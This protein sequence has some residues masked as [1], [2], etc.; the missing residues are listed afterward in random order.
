MHRPRIS[1]GSWAFSFGPFAG[2]PWPFDRLCR[3]A[4]EAGYEG[5]E[6]NGFRPHPHPDDF[7]TAQKCLELRRSI[8]DLGLGVSGYA[9][10]FRAAP[11]ALARATEYFRVLDRCLAFCN[12]MGTGILRVD[13]VSPPVALAAHEYEARFARLSDTWRAA[14]ERCGRA[15]VTMVWEFEPGFWLN[16]P[17]EVK[18]LVETVAH[19]AFRVLFDASHAHMGAVVGARQ[20][21][22]TETLRGGV[23]EYARL[24]APFVGHLH[25]IDSDGG[26][27]DG[28]T[29][30]H[31]PF[32]R[33]YVDF[34]ALMAALGPALDRLPW[35]CVDFCFCPNTALDARA[36][37]TIVRRL[38]DAVAAAR[39]RVT[40]AAVQATP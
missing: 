34:P 18:R 24:L 5:V 9:P 40:P 30:N 12:H 27:H 17:S 25:L 4:G 36:A 10:D 29:S 31:V 11:P 3:Y 16:K 26:L 7:D 35:W 39:T 23:A 33:G 32:G 13:S 28:E 2:N 37:V 1:L 6:I 20:I 22:G 19:P 21:G 8:D 15:G 38:R 14:A